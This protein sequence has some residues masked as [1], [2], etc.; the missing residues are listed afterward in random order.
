M[1]EEGAR[2]N[3]LAGAV[4]AVRRQDAR[5]P[6][7]AIVLGSGLG[8]LADEAERATIFPYAALPGMPVS[9]VAGHAGRLVL[10]EL[11]GTTCVLLQ[12]RAHFYEGNSMAEA[13][14]AVRLAAALGAKTLILTNAAGGINAGFQPGDVMTIAD[15]VFLPGMAG[16][17]PLRG[18]NDDR[19][20]P[21]F[22][23]MTD[24]Y[25]PDLRVLALEVAGA[26]DVRCHQG[27]YAMVAGPS[28]ETSAELRF[29]RTIGADAVGMSTCPEV[30]MA[31]HMGLRVLGL[32][33]IANLALP[34]RPETLTHAMVVA[35]S[36]RGAAGVAAIIRGVL[37]RLNE[38]APP[39]A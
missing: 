32:S 18:P 11:V 4:A 16:F 25:D 8:A 1:A 21:R 39:S 35:A 19:I 9:T 22:P 6:P 2:G 13:T 36:E 15:H 34:E 33:L 30:V 7:V 27:V 28:Y 5:V 26:A 24:A 10:G 29:L 14:A 31:R 37:R 38:A 23:A 17:H 20:G 12:G 3:L